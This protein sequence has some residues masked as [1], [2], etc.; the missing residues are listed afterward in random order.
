MKPN[1]LFFAVLLGLA[2]SAFA[3]HG[4]AASTATLTPDSAHLLPG[5]GT[6]TFTA[7]LAGHPGT[8]SAVGWSVAL[9]AGWA[10]VNGLNEPGVKPAANTTGTLEWA[11]ISIPDDATFTFTV[12][13]P[14]GLTASH[15]ITTAVIVRAAGAVE[16]VTPAAVAFA[17]A[18]APVI[19]SA[20]TLTA[21]Y[22]S[23]L[24]YNITATSPIAI[25]AYA[26]TGLPT[27]LTVDTGTG[28][29]SGAPTQ[30]GSF[31][32]TLSAT[33]AAGTGSATATLTVSQ[34]NASI[35][36]FDLAHTY[37]GTPKPAQA[38]TTP[39]ALTVTLTY[40]GATTAPT[41]AGSYVV[42]ASLV[43]PDY[44]ATASGTLNIA[45]AAQTI[46]FPSAGVVQPGQSVTLDASASSGLP[47]T[48]AVI[49]GSATLTGS[50]LSVTGAGNVTVRASQAG[51]ANYLAAMSDQTINSAKLAQTIDFPALPN[52]RATDASF[53]IAASASS[54]LAVRLVVISGPALLSDRTVT[55]T[56]AAGTVV[57]RATQAGN[58][59]YN[60]APEVTRS[61]DVTAERHR[62]FFGL[63]S[64]RAVRAQ[65]AGTVDHMAAAA[66]DRG[67]IAVVLPAN[68]NEGSLLIVAPAIG[69][70]A[71]VPFTLLDDATF[72]TS[73]AQHATAV[74]TA[75]RTVTIRGRLLGSVLS[76]TFDE[77]GLAFSTDVEPRDGPS[78][79]A[80]GLYRSSSLATA[81][82]VTY[83][84]LGSSNRVLVLTITPTMTVG[85]STTLQ[86][87]GAFTLQA[88]AATGQSAVTVQGVVDTPT[89]TVSGTIVVPNEPVQEFAGLH[90]STT[91]T[92]RLIN[93]SSRARVGSGER[94]LITGFVLGGTQPKPVMIRAVGPALQ[95]LGVQSPLANP[96]ITVFRKGTIVAENDDWGS[97]ADPAAIAAVARRV[98]AFAL[99]RGSTD[100]VLLTTLTPG[101][102]T[103]HISGGEGV[104]LGEIYD[105][106]ENPQG[107]YQRLINISSRGEVAP[108]EAV[109]I[110]GFV[111]TGNSP[112]RVLVRGIGPGLAAQGIAGPLADPVLKIFDHG[113]QLA[114]N[115]DW[116]ANAAAVIEAA[117]K[118]G[119]FALTEGS[120][121]AA[122]VV[123]LA[124]GIYSALVEGKGSATGIAM[125]EIY[126]LAD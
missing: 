74:V 81:T 51:N 17:P 24:S 101:V 58:S 82:G 29:I 21:S 126:E 105:A 14:A 39:E 37:D 70:D 61:F 98:G 107:E 106:S 97:N 102:Y 69:I 125:V 12:S 34:A 117:R 60:A 8:T 77:L 79:A 64:D 119:A 44:T 1:P 72:T 91:R 55:L 35:E 123:T 85:G 19:T 112:K 43:S 5:G 99:T 87:G 53:A 2:L 9:P 84:V 36:L 86:S 80:A 59:N 116:A 23:T 10:Y 78:A 109:L 90:T 41:N 7:S 32:L 33:N 66:G 42:A 4:Y 100:A 76:G 31:P 30:T 46:S 96:R 67:D 25:S 48:F 26:A 54:G 110:G 18:T 27:G 83:T 93:L 3:S 94:I 22:G 15:S 16:N 108:G 65:S 68:C 115:D 57:I 75:P 120:R 121:D 28:L 88:D 62:I 95:P 122:V 40:D 92:D 11:Y 52:R 13:Y 113:I 118:T 111:V 49:S 38:R 89:T 124:P 56:G 114:E 73:V 47:V 103:T 104:A 50:T 20:T 45:K 71:L 6:V 63:V